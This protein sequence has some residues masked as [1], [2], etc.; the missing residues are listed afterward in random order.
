MRLL[1][2]AVLYIPVSGFPSP[3][4]AGHRTAEEARSRVEH[5]LQQAD[6]I[7]QHFAGVLKQDCQR[8]DRPDEW[9]TYID[10]EL[11]RAVLLM[12]HLEQAWVEAKHTPDKDVRRAAK[13]PRAQVARA[14][15]LVTKLQACAGDNGATFDPAAAWRRVERD[16]PRRQAE[17]A[18]PQ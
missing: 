8:F 5:H 16:A 4:S 1:S 2:L 9:R 14:Q 18:L 12:A 13:A 6:Q 3:A 17:I 11:D 10:G 15:R 7:A